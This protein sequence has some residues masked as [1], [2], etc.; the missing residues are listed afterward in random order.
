ML[1]KL[2]LAAIRKN[3]SLRELTE[4]TVLDNPISQFNQWMQ[5]ALMAQIDEPTAMVLSTANAAGQPSA[6]V[7]LLKAVEEGR[8]IFYSNYNSRKGQEIAANDRVALTF[9][10]PALERQVRIEGQVRQVNPI[11]SDEYFA[12][13]PRGSQVGAWASPQSQPIASRREL[14]ETTAAYQQQ[15]G[16]ETPI[17]RPAHWG[18]YGVLPTYVEFWQGGANRLH[19]RLTFSRPGPEQNWRL[20]R[21]AP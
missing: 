17:P 2:D 19:D 16:A 3:Y 8:F 1:E 20:Q 11:I 21:L 18:G 6:R 9:F 5:E 14:E 10:W 7:G 4:E 12:I 15:F 13:R